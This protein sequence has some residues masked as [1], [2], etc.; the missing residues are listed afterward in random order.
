MTGASDAERL[1]RAALTCLAEPGDT[2]MCAL[3]SR[4]AGT[5]LLAEIIEGRLPVTDPG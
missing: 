4:I 1:A 2:G 5:E 3:V